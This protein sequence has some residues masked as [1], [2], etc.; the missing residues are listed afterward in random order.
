MTMKN[1]RTD[2]SKEIESLSKGLMVLEA[3]EGKSFEPV[4]VKKIIERTGLSRN[5]VDRVL[6]TLKLRGYAIQDDSGKWTIGKRFIRFA[7]AASRQDW[8]F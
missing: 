5:I 4:T 3:M 2:E 6:I 8:D 7:V 1:K